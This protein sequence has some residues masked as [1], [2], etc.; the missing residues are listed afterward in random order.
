MTWIPIAKAL[1][2]F[3]F[4]G[5]FNASQIGNMVKTAE[6][7]FEGPYVKLEE[8]DRRSPPTPLL[9]Q[10]LEPTMEALKRI[11]KENF[12]YLLDQIADPAAKVTLSGKRY[13]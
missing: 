7:K 13:L 1:E 12:Q 5:I 11:Y 9:K 4:S 8:I 6:R 3:L 2:K 10:G